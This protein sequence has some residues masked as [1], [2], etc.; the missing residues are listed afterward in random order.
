MAKF[1]G[2]DFKNTQFKNLHSRLEVLQNKQD[3]M[4]TLENLTGEDILV[5]SNELEEI[6]IKHEE[7]IVLDFDVHQIETLIKNSIDSKTDKQ[8]NR[9]SNKQNF[10][11][12]SPYRFN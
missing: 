5:S 8:K 10:D 7:K 3:Y 9:D 11:S 2:G 6:M 12:Q 1:Y 4:Y